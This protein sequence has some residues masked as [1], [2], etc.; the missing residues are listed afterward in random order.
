MKPKSTYSRRAKRK[1]WS[2]K[3]GGRIEQH[4]ININKKVKNYILI[5]CTT[6]KEQK[7]CILKLEKTVSSSSQLIKLNFLT[8]IR[9]N[10]MAARTSMRPHKKW[11]LCDV[12]KCFHLTMHCC[13][14]HIII[15]SWHVSVAAHISTR[16]KKKVQCIDFD[17]LLNFHSGA[18]YLNCTIIS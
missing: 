15:K 6:K 8:C 10:R 4:D 11:L 18:L 16:E 5:Y 14:S 9:W 17:Y 1:L 13:Y 7:W 12:V 2:R 3:G